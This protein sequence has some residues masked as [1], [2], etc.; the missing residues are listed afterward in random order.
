MQAKCPLHFPNFKS[1][2]VVRPGYLWL[3]LPP[4]SLS[5][6]RLLRRS[7]IIGRCRVLA[8][9]PYEPEPPLQHSSVCPKAFED[10]QSSRV[11]FSVHTVWTFPAEG[12]YVVVLY[13]PSAMDREHPRG[14]TLMV[15]DGKRDKVKLD[16]F[17][18]AIETAK[19]LAETKPFQTVY[20]IDEPDVKRTIG[21]AKPQ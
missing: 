19:T 20:V 17:T 10:G 3:S 13:G 6:S 2:E 21:Q 11:R 8:A 15:R 12:S 4:L 14:R 7:H 1:V 16:E 5:M 18:A 9:N